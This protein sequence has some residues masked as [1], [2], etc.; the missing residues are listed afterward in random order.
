MDQTSAPDTGGFHLPGRGE[1]RVLGAIRRAS[2]CG[3]ARWLSLSATPSG[4]TRRP[5]SRTSQRR[6]LS[7]LEKDITF[8]NLSSIS[9]CSDAR[10]AAKFP[11][12]GTAGPAR[13]TRQEELSGP[14]KIR[15]IAAVVINGIIGYC[16]SCGDIL[17]ER[18]VIVGAT[19]RWTQRRQT[20]TWRGP[21]VDRAFRL[22]LGPNSGLGHLSSARKDTHT[23]HPSPDI[24]IRA[25]TLP[26]HD[27]LS[28]DFQFMGASN[29]RQRDSFAASLGDRGRTGHASSTRP[30]SSNTPTAGLTW[31]SGGPARHRG[32]P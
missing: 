25:W 4:T 1:T 22:D 24:S 7:S 28:S 19:A 3:T 20:S 10:P 6:R 5:T 32:R 14:P 15:R 12:D 17:W 26:E 2:R 8:L 31:R 11:V 30:S 18:G 16:A 23:R 29:Y 27:G 9:R 21:C 13:R